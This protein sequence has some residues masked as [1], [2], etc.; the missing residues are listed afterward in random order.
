MQLYKKA[1]RYSKAHASFS[2]SEI[3]GWTSAICLT[4]L[5]KTCCLSFVLSG[6]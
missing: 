5:L 4:G 6:S 1:I 2:G 3:L